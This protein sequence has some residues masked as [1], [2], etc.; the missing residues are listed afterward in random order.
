MK[1][2]DTPVLLAL[3]E[4]NVAARD[5]VRRLK[6]VE[7]VT[8]EANLL[9]LSW[10]AARG[11]TRLRGRRRAAISRLRRKISV[12]PIDSRAVAESERRL[13]R[14]WGGSP[15]L[16]ESMVGALSANGCE[17]LYTSDPRPELG[18]VP[19]RVTRLDITGSK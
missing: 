3:L 1:A 11:P 8:T 2:L 19:F 9:E 6:G 14:G 10:L 15:P 5:L 4:G 12:F 18:R 16:V 7:L 13:A 17:E